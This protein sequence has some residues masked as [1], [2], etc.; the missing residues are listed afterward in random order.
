MLR[1]AWAHAT[2]WGCT[3]NW[4]KSYIPWGWGEFISAV[5]GAQTRG[6]RKVNTVLRP[7]PVPPS[8]LLTLPHYLPKFQSARNQGNQMAT[9]PFGS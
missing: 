7:T 2:Y 8:C 1:V 4:P 9:A 3:E 6:R 5:P